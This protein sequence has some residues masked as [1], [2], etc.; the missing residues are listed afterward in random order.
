MAVGVPY[1]D[2]DGLTDV[3]MVV[4]FYGTASGLS[5]STWE[6]FT[7]SSVSGMAN[8]DDDRFGHTLAAGDFDGDG[9]D[10]L[11][12]G[13]PYEDV[14][15]VS[16]GGAVAIF[17]GSGSGLLPSSTEVVTQSTIAGAGNEADDHFGY[18]LAAG[19][20]DGDGKDDLAIGIPLEN[21]A[22]S[23]SGSV[24]V[25]YGSAGGLLP[26][27]FE[28]IDQ[29]GLSGTTSEAEDRFGTSLAAGDLDG[30]GDDE[31]VIGVPHEDLSSIVDAGMVVILEGSTAGLVP[32]D[33]RVYFQDSVVGGAGETGDKFGWAVAV[34]DFDGD[35]HADVAASAPYED[36]SAT[37]DGHLA[38]L[39]GTPGTPPTTWGEAITELSAHANRETGDL[40]GYSLTTGDFDG[41]GYVDLAAGVPYENDDEI[42]TTD[43]GAVLAFFGSSA[44]LLPSRAYAFNQT[45]VNGAR[46]AFDR[47][48]QVLAAGDFDGDGRWS[49]AA[50]VPYEDVGTV[51]DA[52]AV[53]VRTIEPGLPDVVGAAAIV[54]DRT[55]G[56]V[57]GIKSPDVW[58]ASASTT[59]MMTALLAVEAIA[60]GT[61]SLNDTVTIQSDVATESST[62][63][64]AP[65]DTISLR[66]LL[67]LTMLPSGNDAAVAVGTYI[68]GTRANFLAA[69]NSRAAALGL[70]D[71]SYRSISGIDAEDLPGS[72]C[73]GAPEDQFE[74][75]AC[76]H[77]STARDLAALARHAL[78]KTLFRTLVGTTTWTTTTWSA[79]NVTVSNTNRLIKSSSGSAYYPDAYGVKTGTTDLAGSNLVSA[80]NDGSA[81]VIA[82]ILGSDDNDTPTGDRYTDSHTLLDFGLATAP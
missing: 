13:V 42:G 65:G 16:N 21:D 25:L 68:G 14:G 18:S 74:I 3:G 40:A 26:V 24:A 57:L 38:V 63:G 27:D 47:F 41:D 78:T 32:L 54:I 79:G 34:G 19:D 44:G 56:K 81:D 82:V 36:F 48:G 76:A 75:S 52:G 50:G 1:E 2:Q 59:K 55:T 33:D 23:N 22:V 51:A 28:L 10:D 9:K 6:K 58:R 64:L 11:A 45:Y 73:S 15:T 30:D 69:M 29:S 20:F 39:Y 17:Y 37:D 12:V 4:V 67:Y 43:A 70:D 46:E 71:T 60:A 61:K 72:T 5:P 80:A 66:D 49:I 53:F 8:E 7:Q 35:G 62:L 31:L 77:Y